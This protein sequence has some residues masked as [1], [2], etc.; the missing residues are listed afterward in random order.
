[1][2]VFSGTAPYL[3]AAAGHAGHPALHASYV[4][5]ACVVTLGCFARIATR[6]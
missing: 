3:A 5:L 2:S 1:M 6:R 4:A